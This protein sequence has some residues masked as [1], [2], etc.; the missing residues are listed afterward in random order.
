MVVAPGGGEET[1]QTIAAAVREAV[2]GDVVELRYNGR[3]VERPI[4]LENLRLTIL[5]GEGFA[6]QVVFRPGSEDLDPS[7]YARSMLRVTGG[8]LSLVNVDLQ[9][10]VPR[11]S[12]AERWSLIET[13]GDRSVRLTGCT[14]SVQNAADDGSAYHPGVAFFDVKAPLGTRSITFEQ[15]GIRQ[16]PVTIRL[17]NC[18]ARGEASFLYSEQSQ[19]IDF[20]WDNGLLAI[21]DRFLTMQAGAYS[22]QARGPQVEHAVQVELLHLTAVVLDGLLSA[23]TTADARYQ[24]NVEFKCSDSIIV[25]GD[26]AALIDQRGIGSAQDAE[27]FKQRFSW[28]GT[29]NFYER[30][31][32]FVTM[33]DLVGVEFDRFDFGAWRNHWETQ[34]DDYD[35]RPSQDA[36]VWERLADVQGPLHGR[37]VADYALRGSAADNPARGGASDLTD[38]GLRADDLPTPAVTVE[39]PST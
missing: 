32:D 15:F 38:A 2:S 14:L 31:H 27:D 33:R 29:H 17:E 12:G 4:S 30:F 10:E 3:H 6:P 24:M 39:T 1:Y 16:L 18:I 26:H 25:V 20:S 28:K 8:E 21:S 34:P 36:V 5:A 37:S 9:L 19:P 22:S 11:S 13:R 23:T 35:D 7:T